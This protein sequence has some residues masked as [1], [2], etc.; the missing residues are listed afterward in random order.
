VQ[1]PRVVERRG[2]V[3][4][5]GPAG[6]ASDQH[7]DPNPLNAELELLKRARRASESGDA[8]STLTLLSELDETFPRGV[9][10]QERAA[11]RAM[12]TC[13]VAPR[14][15][16]QALSEFERSYPASVYMS[17]VRASCKEPNDS[18]SSELPDT[19]EP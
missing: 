2:V 12:A 6:A 14:A 5:Q 18:Q 3:V 15:G 4:Q 17:K 16:A 11:L 8:G 19:T 13:R 7:Q 10:L 9:L 1:K